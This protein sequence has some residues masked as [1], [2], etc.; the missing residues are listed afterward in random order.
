MEIAHLDS[1]DQA[2]F[3]ADLGLEG[4]APDRFVKA[5]WSL[6]DTI[7][8]LTIGDKEVRAWE[9]RRGTPAVR[10]AGKV[11][12]DIERGFIRA[13]VIP[14]EVLS[15]LGSEL[16]CKEKGR[17]RLEGK[18]YVVVDGDVIRYRFNV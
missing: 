4:D 12:T 5:T 6:L 7:C 1:E 13:E 11:H 14:F 16:V 18:E 10:A 15:E 17:M 2:D 3:L 8:F 9:V